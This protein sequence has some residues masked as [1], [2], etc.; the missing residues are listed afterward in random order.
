MSQFGA[1]QGW[2]TP[3]RGTLILSLARAKQNVCDTLITLLVCLSKR[4]ARHWLIYFL[5]N[6]YEWKY[7]SL[8]YEL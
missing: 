3:Y 6:L 2:T 4:R 1:G 7:L 5:R 8:P